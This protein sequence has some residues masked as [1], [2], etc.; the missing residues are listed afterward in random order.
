M[1]SSGLDLA[2]RSE[3]EPRT[4]LI[5]D[6]RGSSPEVLAAVDLGS[7]SF[8]MVVARAVEGQLVVLDR[9]RDM[10]RLAAGIDGN[11]D[12][13][14]DSQTRA[15]E[16]LARFG[17]RLRD[18]PSGRVRVV[19]TNT[20]RLARQPTEFLAACRAALGHPVEIISGIEEARLVYMGVS[21]S[22]PTVDGHTLV[23]DIGGGS[24]EVVLGD[25]YEPKLMESLFM[26]CV[27]FS[28]RFFAGGQF[29]AKRFERAKVAAALELAPV[30][31]A[32]RRLGFER[33]LGSSG[34]ARAIAGVAK[35][36][37]LTDGVV[38][39]DAVAAIERR[40]VEARKLAN[41][42]LPGL[43]EQRS[44]VFAG[45]LAIMAS[46]LEELGIERLEIAEGALREGVLYD[47]LGR[48][49]DEDSRELTVTSLMG[50]YHVDAEQASRVAAS[51]HVLFDQVAQRWGL[52]GNGYR[53]LLRWAALLHEVGLDI[54]HAKYHQHGA[55]LIQ[56]GD[57]PG[58]I[59]EEQRRLAALVGTHRRK[60]V[61]E[62]FHDI[63][64]ELRP[65]CFYLSV[66]LRLSVLLNRNRFDD[67]IPA[68]QAMPADQSIELRFPP[69]WL[70]ANPLTE[71]DLVQ[72]KHYLANMGFELRVISAEHA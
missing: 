63:P 11:G 54:A 27:G 42:Q 70:K 20:L 33:A 4:S 37:E 65:A 59:P 49:G 8:H 56:N 31:A 22:M 41:L 24:T 34:T 14:A 69:G 40:L 5:D 39:P 10:V 18:I 23:I 71:A 53:S 52:R 36:M 47:L 46:V 9:L 72:E 61:P 12:L 43:T 21:R 32:F 48:L 45:G 60:L 19:G 38:T 25:G 3:R 29:N 13:D 1:K 15:L 50:R 17:E 58:F 30:Q 35:E 7:N 6:E 16:C 57:L 66:L 67:D 26:G 68:V 28:N 51:S 62:Q 64:E 44:P 2:A 55:Y